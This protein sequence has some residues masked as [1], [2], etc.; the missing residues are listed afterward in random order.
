MNHSARYT[1]PIAFFVSLACYRTSFKKDYT[2]TIKS[3]FFFLNFLF[4][5]LLFFF[6]SSQVF[7]VTWE[8]GYGDLKEDGKGSWWIRIFAESAC[9]KAGLV[10]H[11]CWNTW[12]IHSWSAIS[13][14]QGLLISGLCFDLLVK[15]HCR[16]SSKNFD[17]MIFSWKAPK[18]PWNWRPRTSGE[19]ACSACARRPLCSSASSDF[20]GN[21]VWVQRDEQAPRV[22]AE[23]MLHLLL[24]MKF[25]RAMNFSCMFWF[26]LVMGILD[27]NW[28]PLNW[29]ENCTHTDNL[30]TH[31]NVF[32]NVF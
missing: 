11:L 9:R 31:L 13:K 1:A 27:S 17:L 22:G 6:S 7:P 20:S 10:Y 5:S 15:A 18:F 3:V 16:E 24:K 26:L 30:I 2:W 14:N 32:K 8:Y 19:A 29:K 12:V 28:M 4:H 21:F 23:A 25:T